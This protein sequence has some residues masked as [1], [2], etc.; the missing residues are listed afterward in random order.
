MTEII[1]SPAQLGCVPHEFDII[2]SNPIT[3][4]HLQI[5]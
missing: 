2:D 4:F 5:I 1:V 3:S